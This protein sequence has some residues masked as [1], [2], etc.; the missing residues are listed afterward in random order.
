M[1]P[2]AGRPIIEHLLDR[3]GPPFTDACIVTGPDGA[4]VAGRLGTRH[5]HLRLHYLVQP[6]PLGVAHAVGQAADLVAEPFVAVMGDC[7]YER[8]LSNFPVR[9][10]GSGAEGAVLVEPADDSDGQPMGLVRVADRRVVEIF[11][12]P[13]GGETDWRVS[14]AYLLPPAFFEALGDTRP[15]ASGGLELEDV[16]SRLMGQGAT[17]QAIPYAG[18]RRNINTPADLKAVVDRITGGG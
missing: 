8:P 17:F 14:G 9:W 15:A 18:W 5:E 3:L 10:S 7:Y 16:V 1:L 6:Y 11:K 12:K 2:V 13:W 4:E